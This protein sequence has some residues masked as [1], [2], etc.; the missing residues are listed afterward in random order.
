ME[1]FLEVLNFEQF[2]KF[3]SIME[4][5]SQ[6][7]KGISELTIIIHLNVKMDFFKKVFL[8]SL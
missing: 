4:F 2:G 8:K 7:V 5:H 3:G 1:S 6:K